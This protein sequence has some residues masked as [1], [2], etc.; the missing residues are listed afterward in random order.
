MIFCDAAGNSAQPF[1]MGTIF[2]K[3]EEGVG[4]GARVVRI[5]ENNPRCWID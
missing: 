5:I 2:R 1:P 4:E 3:L